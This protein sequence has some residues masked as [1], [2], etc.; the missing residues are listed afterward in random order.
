M[1]RA[2]KITRTR[3]N[4]FC[5]NNGPRNSIFVQGAMAQELIHNGQLDR[6]AAADALRDF[7]EN[8]VRVAGFQLKVNVQVVEPGEGSDP[9][10]F[11]DVDGGDKEILLERNAEVLKA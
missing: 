7:L 10:V 2:A 6:K 9:E 8:I 3:S 11:A 4:K 5:R 1:R